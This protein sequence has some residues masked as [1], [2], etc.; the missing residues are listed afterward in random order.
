M[1]KKLIGHLYFIVGLLNI[2]AAMVYFKDNKIMWGI[3]Y[4]F[5]AIVFISMGVLYR[6]RLK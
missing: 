3:V 6:K 1:S 4:V 5:I 2:F